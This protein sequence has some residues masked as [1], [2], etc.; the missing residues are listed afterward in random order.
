MPRSTEVLG[1]L[2]RAFDVTGVGIT[3]WIT[4]WPRVE[5][6]IRRDGSA[7]PSNGCP[8][9]DRPELNRRL[10]QDGTAET[11]GTAGESLLLAVVPGPD[12]KERVLW[13]E[14]AVGRTWTEAEKAA[15]LLAA[16][17]V[18]RALP[19]ETCSP[20]RDQAQLQQRLQD[21]ALISG[22]VAHAFDNVLTGILGFAELTLH[23]A[24]DA[25]LQQYLGEVLQ[26]AQNGIQL[27]QQLHL[28]HRCAVTGSGPTRVA[29][30]M[31]DEEMRL[32]QVLDERTEL[33]VDVPNDLPAVALDGEPLR[34][35][36]AQLLNN[37]RESLAGSGTIRVSARAEELTTAACA[38]LYGSPRPGP[39]VALT[40][41]DS[42]GGLSAEARQRLFHEPFFTTKP[43]HRGLGL[44]VVY[45]IL[46]AHHG[47]FQLE[48]GPER[49]TRAHVYLP[50]ASASAAPTG[51]RL[52]SALST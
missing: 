21:A 49:G 12:G 29:A 9:S 10:R 31:L 3:G 40:V 20:R 5:Q 33:T 25:T 43:R 8:W 46:H 41:A 26:A 35:V 13:L 39:C 28:F 22:R 2:S 36:L 52:L 27:T 37:A 48:A 23:Q 32:R 14:A 44:A 45:R 4:D 15:L 16:R 30:I 17:V 18:E 34:Q 1:E 11:S 7:P 42:G 51:A 19:G 50:L 38:P 24:S 47:G 6:R